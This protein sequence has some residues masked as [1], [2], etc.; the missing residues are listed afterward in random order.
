MTIIGKVRRFEPKKS[1]R[2]KRTNN[3][4]RPGDTFTPPGLDRA[5][6]VYANK[7]YKMSN[8][9]L[10]YKNMNTSAIIGFL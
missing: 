1:N 4:V 7:I 10:Q 9:L 5:K 6:V 3:F 8:K 2:S